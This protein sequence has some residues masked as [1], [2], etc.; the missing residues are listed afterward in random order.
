MYRL[1]REALRR[2]KNPA[3]QDSPPAAGCLWQ[4]L[5][6]RRMAILPEGFTLQDDL[7]WSVFEKCSN[8]VKNNF[9]TCSGAGY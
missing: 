2:T 8:K 4:H 3:L 9:Q 6:F 7:S 1:S 5:P